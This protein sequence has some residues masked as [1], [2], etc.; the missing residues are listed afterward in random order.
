[1]SKAGAEGMS[2]EKLSII[3]DFE[4][5]RVQSTYQCSREDAACALHREPFLDKDDDPH[6]FMNRAG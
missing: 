2:R 5:W 3:A 6:I 1:M 4:D